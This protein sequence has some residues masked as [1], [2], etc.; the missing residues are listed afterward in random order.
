MVLVHSVVHPRGLHPVM[1]V[2]AHH[3][4]TEEGLSLRDICDEVHNMQGKR[5]SVKCVWSGVKRTNEVLASSVGKVL[6]ETGYKKCGRTDLLTDAQKLQ[7]LNFVEA[8]R[9]KRFC[10]CAYISKELALGVSRQTITRCLAEFWYRWK[11]VSKKQRLSDTQLKAREDFWNKYGDKNSDWWISSMNRVL[12]GVTLTTAPKGLSKREKHAAQRIQHMWLKDGESLDNDLHTHNRYGTQLGTKVPLWGGFTGGS[13]FSLRLWTE[14]PKMDKAA[15]ARL[16]PNVKLAADDGEDGAAAKVWHDNEKFLL[17]P[18][19]YAQHG[20]ELV[21]F[22]PN[23]G[24]LNPIETVWAWL[25]KDLAKRELNDLKAKKGVLTVPQFRARAA[26]I[27]HSYSVPARGEAHSRLEKLIRG[28]P[29]RLRKMKANKFG[30][31]GK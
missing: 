21:R 16:I 10:T 13:S 6:P 7:V 1:A 15:W 12:G 2:R 20:L 8:W 27:L 19:V 25:R 9:S 24:D 23:S 26:Q 18:D 4:Y 30:K 17:Q 5:P 28:M 11:P 14:K 22:P 3:L 31:C 29:K